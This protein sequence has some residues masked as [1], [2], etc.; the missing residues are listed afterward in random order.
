MSSK[1]A[2]A[3]LLPEMFRFGIHKSNQGRMVRQFTFFAIVVVAAFGCIT[4][5]NGPLMSYG[6]GI[7]VG[8]PV[9]LWLL[10]GWVAFRLVNYPRFADFLVS[11]E[12]EL[13]KVT[14]PGRQEVLQA[15]VVVLC[16]MFFLGLFLFL[17]DLVWT[18][19]FS[20]IGFTEYNTKS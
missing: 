15:T 11:V 7:Q 13:E 1:S 12:S 3:S 18:W 17:I 20:F 19:L 16:T 9:A 4:L 5:S 2:G 6:K 10:C 14:W 8:I